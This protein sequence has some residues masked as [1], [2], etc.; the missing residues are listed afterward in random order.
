MIFTKQYAS[1]SDEQTEVISRDY[2]FHYRSCVG[3]LIHLFFTREDLCFE[4]HNL[5]NFLSNPGKLQFECLV[6]SN[7]NLPG[8]DENFSRLCTSKHKSTIVDKI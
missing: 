1:T 6:H 7:C 8:F 5:G 3:S 2:N 4:V